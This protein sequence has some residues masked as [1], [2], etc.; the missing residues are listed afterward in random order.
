MS[1]G[2]GVVGVLLAGGLGRRMGGGDKCLVPLGGRTLL[3]GAVER[4]RPQV[5]ELVLNANGDPE[6]FAALGCRSWPTASPASPGR[7]R[8]AGR[9]RL[10][11]G[12]AGRAL[13]GERGERHAVLSGGILVARLRNAAEQEGAEVACA[14]SRGRAHP[15]FGL[16]D[17]RL[18]PALR[19]ALTLEGV[20]KIDRWTAGRRTVTVEF[21][22]G[23]VDPFFNLNAP[24]RH[25]RGR[26]AAGGAGFRRR[27][28]GGPAACALRRRD[29]RCVLLLLGPLPVLLQGAGPVGAYE[30]VANRILWSALFL[31]CL[32]PFGGAYRELLATLRTRGGRRRCC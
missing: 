10:G 19:H 18:A 12:P 28:R 22:S 1:E 13:G 21:P 20:R 32:L 9:A 3:K 25:G 15:V 2:K 4:L 11:G 17:V 7:S 23:G 26:T 6:R 29:R 14:A 27:G 5:D 31:A 24:E 16:W 30:V 8:H